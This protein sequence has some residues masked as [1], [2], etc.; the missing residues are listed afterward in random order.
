MNGRS[1]V[2]IGNPVCAHPHKKQW[3]GWFSVVDENDQNNIGKRAT[4]REH[5]N[6]Y[7]YCKAI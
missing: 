5:S 1:F 4:K 6:Y 2:N 7:S 3:A